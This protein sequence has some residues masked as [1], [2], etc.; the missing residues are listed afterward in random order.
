MEERNTEALM[1][2]RLSLRVQGIEIQEGVW[3]CP[4]DRLER[5]NEIENLTPVLINAQS[6]VVLGIDA[7]WGEGKVLLLI[8]GGTTSNM[9][10]RG[11]SAYT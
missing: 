10:K 8:S 11:T 7:P 2:Q 6:P 4:A 5:H 1:N 9:E 3:P